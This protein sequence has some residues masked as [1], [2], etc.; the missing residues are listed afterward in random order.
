MARAA[1]AETYRQQTRMTLDRADS[2][3]RL[4]QIKVPTLILCGAHDRTCPP[5][6]SI[7]MADAIPHARRVIVPGVG[8]YL[9]LERPDVVANELAA[10]L[11]MP[12]PHT[13]KE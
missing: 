12:V 3:P 13:T 7:A 4:S 5:A 10:W 1:S 8:H 9:P 6:M 2:Q 11:A